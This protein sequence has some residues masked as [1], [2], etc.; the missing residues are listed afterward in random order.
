MWKIFIILICALGAKIIFAQEQ[1]KPSTPPPPQQPA[2]P[3]PAQPQPPIA[4][5]AIQHS[6]VVETSSE[7]APTQEQVRAMI[8]E[9][10]VRP[11]GKDAANPQQSDDMQGPFFF[12]DESPIQV[13]RILEILSDKTVLQPPTIPAVK[14]NF[15][16]K[17]KMTRAEA[18]QAMEALLS[19]N[20]IAIIPLNEKFLKAVPTLGVNAQTPQFLK[21]DPLTL[22]A[23]INF[24]TKLFEFQ[25]MDV[26]TMQPKL[27][28]FM[29]PPGTSLIEIFPRNNSILVTDTLMNL[30]RMQLLI[31][32]LDVPAEIR[33][34]IEFVQL[35]NTSAEDLK[36]R[37]TAMQGDGMKKYFEKTVI[38][39]DS[40]TNQVIVI[41]NKGNLPYIKKFIEGFDI[42]AEPLLKST[43]HYIKHS[44]ASKVVSVV[45]NIIS[46]QQQ[47]KAA[48]TKN[49]AANTQVKAAQPPA[50]PNQPKAAK[51]EPETGMQ[52]SEY[53][54]VVADEWSNS[55][56]AYGTPTDLKQI[57][58]IIE[59][60]DIQLLQVKIDV[61]IT[62]VTLTDGQVSGLSTF[63][64]GYNLT[65]D[66]PDAPGF[67]GSTKTYGLGTKD[68]SAF[69]LAANESSFSMV[70]NVAKENQNVKVLSSP[71]IVTSHNHEA[72][73]SVGQQYPRITGSTSDVVNP[74]STRTTIEQG[75]VGID[76][77]VTPRIGENGVVQMEIKQTVS[78]IV[79]YTEIDGNQQPIIGNR[80]AQSYISVS[81]GDT[82]VLAGLQQIDISEVNGK[83][84]LL[85]DLPLIGHLF[86]PS[87]ADN[88]R[89]ELVMFIK[90]TIIKSSRIADILAD[91]QMDTSLVGEEVKDYFEDGK[92]YSR[93]QVKAKEKEFEDNRFYNKIYKDP[94]GF[95]LP[96]KDK[97]TTEEEAKRLKAYDEANKKAAQKAANDSEK[98][99][100]SSENIS[101]GN[102]EIKDDGASEKAVQKS[103]IKSNSPKR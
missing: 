43:V 30:Q 19:I 35:K 26:E 60:I 7:G 39:I 56:V 95:I 63:G 9:Q 61:I 93:D 79:S 91:K 6:A 76:L 51:R 100:Q 24:Y 75:K 22:P 94:V 50:T 48:A 41:T 71:T 59:R 54:T 66:Y 84:W 99:I 47:S 85:G 89:R 88:T 28:N 3:V 32:K 64:L 15:A 87:K 40:R 73:V 81:T 5:T 86:N 16:T 20:G 69:S 1:A 68:V 97:F 96:P 57:T 42:E 2:Q 55:I 38:E 11:I 78:T 10:N 4:N 102:S 52:F 83:V 14:I 31:T 33:E 17:N 101:E 46:G 23:S 53:V 27:M 80:E 90:P 65:G 25:Y 72:T 103:I 8:E 92:F 49:R 70:F 37:L 62:E 29:S 77:V 34:D 44:E 67:S 82:I 36:A 58:D 12:V 98:L 74:N 13:I 21:E 45:Q 18:I